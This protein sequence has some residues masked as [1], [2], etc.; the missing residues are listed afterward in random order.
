MSRVD[1]KCPKCQGEMELGFAPDL[2]QGGVFAG[3]WIKGAPKR[4]TWG[5]WIGHHIVKLKGLR[6]AIPI[7]TYRCQS[8]G[9]LESYAREEFR[10]S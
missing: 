2:A 5:R 4:S 8:C 9:Y 6:S 7:G 10:P 3:Q 1:L